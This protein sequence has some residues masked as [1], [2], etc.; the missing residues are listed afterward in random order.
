MLRSLFQNPISASDGN[1]F[2]TETTESSSSC[3]SLAYYAYSFLLI[4]ETSTGSLMDL[5]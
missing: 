5:L 2:G 4:Y 3:P 1:R